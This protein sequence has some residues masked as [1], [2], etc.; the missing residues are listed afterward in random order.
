MSESLSKSSGEKAKPHVQPRFVAEASS[1]HGQDLRRALLL[2]EAAA[3][4]GFAA[5]KFQYFRARELFAS[6]VLERSAFHRSRADWELPV[7]FIPVLSEGARAHGLDFSC[8]PFSL[9]AVTELAPHVDFLK[10]ASYELLWDDLLRECARTGLPLVVSTGMADLAEVDHAVGVVLSEGCEDLTLLHCVSAYPTPTA[11]A[12]LGAIATLREHTGLPVG[13][14]DHTNDP[15]VIHRAV[16]RWGSS[17]VELHLD[18]DGQGAEFAPGHCWL[19]ETAGPLI[20]DLRAGIESDGHGRKEPAPSEE[21]DRVWRADPSDGL[22]PLL[23]ERARWRDG[24][25]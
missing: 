21:P 8:T 11:E 10:V 12:N 24:R 5:V 2:V 6:E 13:W 18:V 3:S 15:A 25:P 1:N 14:S 22:R 7:S 4:S 23:E 20:R 16:H 17:F 9:S 19:P